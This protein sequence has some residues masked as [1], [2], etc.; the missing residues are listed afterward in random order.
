[1]QILNILAP[2]FLLIGLGA[3]L[4]WTRFVSPDFLKEAN[5]VT[6]WLGLPALLFS[7]LVASFP[8]SGGA[9]KKFTVVLVATRLLVAPGY[10]SG[11]V[12]RGPGPGAGHLL[13][14]PPS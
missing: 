8:Q 4:Q 14:P 10:L 2:V 3:V 6:Y 7:Q 11:C 13:P 9:G 12:C 1:M 5:R